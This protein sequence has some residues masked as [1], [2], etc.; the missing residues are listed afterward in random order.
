M[1]KII[2]ISSAL[3]LIVGCQNGS[4]K[5]YNDDEKSSGGQLNSEIEGSKA[6]KK[7]VSAPV[8]KEVVATQSSGDLE[9]KFEAAINS[10]REDQMI[11]S[12]SE[13]LARNPDN[14]KILAGFGVFYLKNNMPDAA[15]IYFDRVLARDPTNAD[16][17][18]GMGVIAVKD[19][20][21]FE[22]QAFF[23]KALAGNRSHLGANANLGA[24]YLKYLDYEKAVSF[25]E[26]AYDDDRSNPNIANNYAIALR[27]TGKIDKAWSI[28]KGIDSRNQ[29]VPVLLNQAI[30]LAEFKKD[31]KGA[32]EFLNK[33]RFITTDPVILKKVNTLTQKLDQE[34][35]K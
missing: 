30:L 1:K 25:L 22:G 23:K 13:L 6:S 2:L 16:A 10:Q 35:T 14:I 17:N 12:G 20:K 11:S 8:E 7:T 21:D 27:G 15:K 32:K 5:N 31:S 28:Y 3:L 24:F 19:N 26:N 9:D 18:N 4:V 29:K 33:I 34:V